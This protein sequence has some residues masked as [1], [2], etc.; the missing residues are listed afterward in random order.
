MARAFFLFV[1]LL[2]GCAP[3]ARSIALSDLDLSN[4][5]TV[6]MIRS[7]LAPK[8]GI[9]FADYVVRHHANSASYCGQPLF[10]ANGEAPETVGEAIDLAARRDA[11]E[12][13]VLNVTQ[14]P[15]HPRTLAK[16]E[17]E[18]LIRDRDV[19]I[20]SQARLR[21]EFGKAAKRRPEWKLLEAKMAENDRKLFALK[22]TVFGSGSLRSILP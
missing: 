22:S 4:M 16:E 10:D 21:L 12:R 14:T 7:Q 5:Q 15:K 11:G 6:R 19:M 20:D 9:A 13:Q 1:G 3:E 18:G 2:G 17:W 8:D